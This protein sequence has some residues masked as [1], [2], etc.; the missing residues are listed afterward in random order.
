MPMIEDTIKGMA[1]DYKINFYKLIIENET[2]FSA[3]DFEQT[4]I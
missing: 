4:N 3:A 1:T 2:I